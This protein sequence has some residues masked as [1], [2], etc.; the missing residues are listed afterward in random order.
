MHNV[1]EYEALNIRVYN[2]K[3]KCLYTETVQGVQSIHNGIFTQN[4]IGTVQYICI[5]NEKL[6][7][8]KSI[9]ISN[10]QY[11]VMCK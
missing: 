4:I 7:V 8:E 3:T 11:E 1:I 6:T 10:S 5:S 9:E 2:T